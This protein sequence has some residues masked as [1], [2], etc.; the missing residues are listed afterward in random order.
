MHPVSVTESC[1]DSSMPGKQKQLNLCTEPHIKM[2][3]VV[4]TNAVPS[5]IL[6]SPTDKWRP[7]G[8]ELLPDEGSGMSTDGTPRPQGWN[9]VYQLAIPETDLA[10]LAPLIA[11][12][13]K[14]TRARLP[15]PL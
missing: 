13:P 10:K 5:V 14:A 3:L 12:A 6:L 4:R 7:G 8:Q 9:E 11:H 2:L 15:G 1:N